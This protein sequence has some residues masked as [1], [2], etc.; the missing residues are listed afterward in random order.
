MDSFARRPA[1]PISRT[2]STELIQRQR[3]RLERKHTRS[4][5]LSTMV[6]RRTPWDARQD[7]VHSSRNGRYLHCCRRSAPPSKCPDSTF[8][9][10]PLAGLRSNS[11]RSEETEQSTRSRVFYALHLLVATQRWS[12]QPSA[13][14]S[15]TRSLSPLVLSTADLPP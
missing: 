8:S 5:S 14:I 9:G 7:L 12:L 2:S 10:C 1:G 4:R 11:A 13:V 3:S 6:L 15:A